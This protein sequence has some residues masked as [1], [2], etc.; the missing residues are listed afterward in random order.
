MTNN[1]GIYDNLIK[2]L[3][4][5][6][7]VK[8]QIANPQFARY[9]KNK[10]EQI[11]KILLKRDFCIEKI[12]YYLDDYSDIYSDEIEEIEE[13]IGYQK[14]Y[15]DSY[16]KMYEFVYKNIGYSN[17]LTY[18]VYMTKITYLTNC[19]SR[20]NTF[21]AKMEL[22]MYICD[23]INK[24]TIKTLKNSI[25]RYPENTIWLKRQVKTVINRFYDKLVEINSEMEDKPGKKIW[26]NWYK[27]AFVKLSDLKYM[28]KD[29]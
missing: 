29:V 6:E 1:V 15:F 28:F 12:H 4:I 13:I 24:N 19:F 5:K 21:R 8:Y 10:E 27:N 11:Y 14:K 23:Y 22:I 17:C 26:D 9:F 20:L 16:K 25:K 3:S 7:I 2:N 18:P